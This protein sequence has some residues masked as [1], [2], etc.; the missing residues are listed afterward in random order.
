MSVALCCVV[1]TVVRLPEPDAD[2]ADAQR[3]DASVVL[4]LAHVPDAQPIARGVRDAA[5]DALLLP[6]HGRLRH[7]QP[8][9]HQRQRHLLRHFL[10]LRQLVRECVGTRTPERTTLFKG[11]C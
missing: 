11:Q 8:G 2:A 6:R 9:G 1:R 7:R 4:L 5:R 3:G 10:L